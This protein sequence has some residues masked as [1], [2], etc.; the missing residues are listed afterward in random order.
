MTKEPI[1]GEG[2]FKQLARIKAD[3]EIKIAFGVTLAGP[4]RK[5]WPALL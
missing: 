2:G 5:K 4:G 1:K 3:K